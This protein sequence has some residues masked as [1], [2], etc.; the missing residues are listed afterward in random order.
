MRI[1]R[2]LQFERALDVYLY[3]SPQKSVRG[4]EKKGR[5]ETFL[6]ELGVKGEENLNNDKTK[7]DNWIKYYN[8]REGTFSTM[9]I[10]NV[11]VL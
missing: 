4:Y 6:Q 2:Q 1:I 5:T 7:K 9:K 3:E 11:Y 10:E 8:F